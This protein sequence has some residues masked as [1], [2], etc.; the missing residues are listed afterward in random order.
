[1]YSVYALI[2]KHVPASQLCDLSFVNA[3]HYPSLGIQCQQ[4]QQQQLLCVTH[5]KHCPTH[6][7]PPKHVQFAANES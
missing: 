7:L 5:G 1:M 3:K 4:Q 2:V 6:V